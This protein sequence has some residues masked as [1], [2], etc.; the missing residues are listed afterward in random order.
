MWLVSRYE[1]FVHAYDSSLFSCLFIS[2]M[3]YVKWTYILI[4]AQFSNIS[5][6][7][8]TFPI[9][10]YVSPGN[11]FNKVYFADLTLFLHGW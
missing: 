3:F 6:F 2:E 4:T 1:S 5:F 11:D 7:A 10:I 9:S 8:I